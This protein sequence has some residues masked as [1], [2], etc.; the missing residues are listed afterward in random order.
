MSP[1][2]LYVVATPIGNLGDLS[3]RAREVLAAVGRIAAEDTRRTGQ[4]VHSF[5]LDTPLI[6]LHEHNETQRSAE[7]IERLR[8]GESIALVS[9]AGTPL[10]SDPGYELVNAARAAGVNV[11]AVPGPC[12]AIAALSRP[13]PPGPGTYHQWLARTA[14]KLKTPGRTA[15]TGTQRGA[16][17]WRRRKA[18][19]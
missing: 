12:A 17:A 6:S 4:L 9:D 15:R 7:L 2:T 19:R 18:R 1:G 16:C 11:V 13:T 14:K 10:I 8:S 3:P 5:G